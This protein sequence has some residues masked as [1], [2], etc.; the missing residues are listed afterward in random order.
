MHAHDGLNHNLVP[1]LIFLK[2]ILKWLNNWV[3]DQSK[4]FS[5][6]KKPFFWPI[7]KPIYHT[8]VEE[9]R[10]WGCSIWKIWVVWVHC[11]HYMQISLNIFNKGFINLLI[12]IYSFC[13]NL[14]KLRQEQH[15]LLSFKK[16]RNLTW[17][18]QR[19]H[20]L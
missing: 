15:I 10:R 5:N 8:S 13:I 20:F 12:R 7:S 9:S 19:V 3:Y 16:P 14:L 1:S 6:L 4:F 17:S 2:F 11:K 18:Q